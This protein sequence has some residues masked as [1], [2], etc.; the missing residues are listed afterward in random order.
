MLT[1][2]TP[3]RLV[4][5]GGM[6]PNTLDQATGACPIHAAAEAK[7]FKTVVW[8]ANDGGADVDAIRADTF[9]SALHLACYTG[10]FE[11]SELLLKQCGANPNY[12]ALTDPVTRGNDSRPNESFAALHFAVLGKNVDIISMLMDFPETDLDAPV[13]APSAVLPIAAKELVRPS[14]L[15]KEISVLGRRGIGF[16]TSLKSAILL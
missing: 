12:R 15:S 9:L 6:S 5:E 14:R 16:T 11:T 7:Q 8:L 13:R 4:M 1:P 10:D 2:L 3:H